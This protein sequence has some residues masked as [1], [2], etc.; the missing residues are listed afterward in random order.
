MR[1]IIAVPLAALV[2]AIGAIVL[3]V[4]AAVAAICDNSAGATMD[5]GACG[6]IHPDDQMFAIL[7][8]IADL[9]NQV[10]GLQF[11]LGL[12]T[13]LLVVVAFA[14]LAQLF[15]AL[16]RKTEAAQDESQDREPSVQT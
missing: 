15:I 13:A 7:R 11:H 4:A 14:S 5:D 16:S 1:R 6:Y 10:V 12:V 8:Q 2:L 3:P 9:E